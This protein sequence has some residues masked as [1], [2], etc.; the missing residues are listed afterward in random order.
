M[1]TPTERDMMMHAF[2]LTDL[3]QTRM[4]FFMQRFQR[5]Q[6]FHDLFF[7]DEEFLDYIQKRRRKKMFFE[8][9]RSI[10]FQKTTVVTRM[11]KR[12]TKKLKASAWR[13]W[14]NDKW[15]KAL[16]QKIRTTDANCVIRQLLAYFPPQ[17]KQ[18]SEQAESTD[19][20]LEFDAPKTDLRSQLLIL[21]NELKDFEDEQTFNKNSCAKFG[22]SYYEPDPPHLFTTSCKPLVSQ[23]QSFLQ[24]FVD[25][26]PISQI[27][28]QIKTPPNVYFRLEFKHVTWI[29]YGVLKIIYNDSKNK[30][31]LETLYA[32]MDKLDQVQAKWPSI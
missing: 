22:F 24:F 18:P 6:R 25:T 26:D 21:Q 9:Y 15:E 2:E 5:Y 29:V 31:Q 20:L 4:S 12:Y 30:L 23:T 16:L 1:T 27:F 32:I 7:H 14:K 19:L 3:I 13:A 17:Q 11:V 28:D 8:I 10:K